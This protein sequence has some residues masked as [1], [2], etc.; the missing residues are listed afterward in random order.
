MH[1]GEL[2]LKVDVAID[3]LSGELRQIDLS[4]KEDHVEVQIDGVGRRGARLLRDANH[5]IVVTIVE[6]G[7]G[8]K[9]L[10]GIERRAKRVDRRGAV[11]DGEG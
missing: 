8:E 3:G 11:H 5:E 2:L 6:Q 1:R 9:Q 7:F 4:L 10:G